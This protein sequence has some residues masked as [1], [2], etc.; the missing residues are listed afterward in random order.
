MDDETTEGLGRRDLLKRGAIVGGA[1]LW[2]TP[3]VQSLASPAFAAGSPAA[4][5]CEF[6]MYIV[7]NGVTVCEHV[8]GSTPDCCTAIAGAN[9]QTDP[10][11]RFLAQVAA[12]AGPCDPLTGGSTVSECA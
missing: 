11:L 7:Q 4:G 1:V 9:A 2:T 12:L 5:S 3:V 10:T 8:E 6:D